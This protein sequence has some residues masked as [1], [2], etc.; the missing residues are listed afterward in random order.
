[1]GARYFKTSG[2]LL[3]CQNQNCRA[4]GADLLLLA[5]TRALEK[6]GLA[7]YKAGGSVRLTATGCLGACQ[8]GPVLACYRPPE[9]AW[10]EAVDLP[11]A[12][13]VARAVHAGEELPQERRYGP[14]PE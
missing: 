11:L 12:L 8:F 6:E 5:L 1:M 2:H 14:D 4:R 10:Y 3:L 9:E 7:Y 13:R